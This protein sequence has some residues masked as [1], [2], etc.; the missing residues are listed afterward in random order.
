MVPFIFNL[1]V[2]DGIMVLRW[3]R[4]DIFPVPCPLDEKKSTFPVGGE[5]EKIKFSDN[6]IGQ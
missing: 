6:S 5:T 3:L 1:S 4:F 2:D